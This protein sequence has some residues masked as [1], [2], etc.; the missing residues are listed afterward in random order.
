MREGAI[1]GNSPAEVVGEC[2]ITFS[3]VSDPTA[4]KDVSISNEILPN[5][6]CG[7]ILEIIT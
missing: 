4:V 6:G 3:C 5:S 1:K 2:D 7:V